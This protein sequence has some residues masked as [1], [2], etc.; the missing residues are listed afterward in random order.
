MINMITLEQIHERLAD[1]IKNSGIKQTELAR[2]LGV[3]NQAIGQY[4]HHNK[5]PALDT[6]ANLCCILDVDPA[7]ILCLID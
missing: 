7:Y 5:F 4:L 3:C 6:F 1:A 2:Q